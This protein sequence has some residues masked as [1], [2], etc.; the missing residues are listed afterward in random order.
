MKWGEKHKD[1][2][3][4]IRKEIIDDRASSTVLFYK[5][6]SFNQSNVAKIRLI[7]QL[8]IRI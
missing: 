7:A 4:G 2:G 6:N 1:D 8:I 3:I 5:Q